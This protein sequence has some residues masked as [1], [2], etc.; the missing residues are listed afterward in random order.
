MTIGFLMRDP[1]ERFG[2]RWDH[3]SSG[4]FRNMGLFVR[5]G[6]ETLRISNFL[7]KPLS[8][9]SVYYLGG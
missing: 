4:T 5:A 8:L 6:D 1:A 2:T 3:A 7:P 9:F